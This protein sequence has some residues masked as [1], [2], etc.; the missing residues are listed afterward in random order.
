[1]DFPDSRLFLNTFAPLYI[2]T[3][4][5]SMFGY[6]ALTAPFFAGRISNALFLN[7]YCANFLT[8]FHPPLPLCSSAIKLFTI[9]MATETT[10]VVAENEQQPIQ[11]EPVCKVHTKND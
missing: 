7:P 8:P 1:M 11:E 6:S 3:T 2:P 4:M 5:S 9:K 10:S